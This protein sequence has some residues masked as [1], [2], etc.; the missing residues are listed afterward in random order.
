MKRVLPVCVCLGVVLAVSACDRRDDHPPVAASS[1]SSSSVS[2]SQ[3]AEAEISAVSETASASSSYAV[4]E[5]GQ[6]GGLWKLTQTLP[7]LDGHSV[8]RI[9]LSDRQGD[10]FALTGQDLIGKPEMDDLTCSSRLVRRGDDTA[11]IDSV[12]AV[13]DTI[14]TSHI[15]VDIVG[16]DAFHQTAETSYSPA[17]AGHGKQVTVTDGKRIGDCPDGMKPGDVTA[18][19]GRHLKAGKLLA[20][21]D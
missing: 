4:A 5:L 10:T 14:L 18:D 11:D 2:V 15:H 21:F 8:L 12:C 13:R 1:S 16:H 20:K 6:R 3:T 19:D 9:C 17:F 7:Q